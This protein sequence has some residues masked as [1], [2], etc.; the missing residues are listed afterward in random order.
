M[1]D[2]LWDYS[3][4]EVLTS[5]DGGLFISVTVDGGI[6]T[7]VSSVESE[8]FLSNPFG[9]AE[10]VVVSSVSGQF[11]P[12]YTGS[13][14][15]MWS[16]IG[17]L[18]FA[19]SINNIAG[20]KA[21][22]FEG[23]A[24]RA[25]R[26]KNT[27][28]V[29]GSGGVS[30]LFPISD[31]VSTWSEL[32]LDSGGILNPRA[33]VETPDGHLFIGRDY[34][35]YSIL[36]NSKSLRS[37]AI[38]VINKLGFRE[39]IQSLEGSPRMFHEPVTRR[40]F[41]SGTNKTLLI[42][43]GEMTEVPIEIQGAIFTST[44]RVCQS[45]QANELVRLRTQELRFGNTNF[46]TLVSIAFD[47]D[48]FNVTLPMCSIYIRDTATKLFVLAKTVK[49]T[50]SG[51]AFPALTCA[52]CMIEVS[53]V[54]LSKLAIRKFDITIQYSDKRFGYGGVDVKQIVA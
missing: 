6:A 41:I 36:E 29:Y 12:T 27:V 37:T 18:D 47:F 15:V 5:V 7:V 3:T 21:L 34:Q 10:I 42:S 26:F 38:P 19:Q 16:D 20:W 14:K 53:F 31:P 49:I 25:L 48:L 9:E 13:N 45:A 23:S 32:L 30:V 43:E 17:S 22:E 40:T 51:Q 50:D 46:K 4:S 28:I 52:E 24:W 54:P 44:L 8:A 33:V 35:L 39:F 1:A 11:V 2:F